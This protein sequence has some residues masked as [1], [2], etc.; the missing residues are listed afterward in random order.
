MQALRTFVYLLV[1]PNDIVSSEQQNLDDLNTAIHRAAAIGA[2]RVLV[3]AGFER[4]P[5]HQARLQLQSAPHGTWLT[6][7]ALAI[8]PP[9]WMPDAQQLP[10]DGRLAA[11]QKGSGFNKVGRPNNPDSARFRG[12]EIFK[13]NLES[14]TD[15][16]IKRLMVQELGVSIA[17]ANTYLHG[18]RKEIE[19]AAGRLESLDRDGLQGVPDSA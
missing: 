17:V 13:A 16:E 5:D 8:R 11:K 6:A 7:A 4:L 12:R 3:H 19:D 14:L 9:N 1:E 2:T 10:E 15:I 18:F